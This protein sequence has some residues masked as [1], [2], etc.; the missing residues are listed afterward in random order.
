MSATSNPWA[1]HEHLSATSVP[2]PTEPCWQRSRPMDRQNS[3]QGRLAHC[4]APAGPAS[5]VAAPRDFAL[6][7][8]KPSSR[9]QQLPIFT[10]SIS[11]RK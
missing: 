6:R 9:C 5:D 2:I 10:P 1:Q 3:G 7:D 8:P 11:W 4:W